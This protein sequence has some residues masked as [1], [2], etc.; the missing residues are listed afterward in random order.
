VKV[1]TTPEHEAAVTQLLEQ[2]PGVLR[3]IA[4]RPG[5]GARTL[6]SPQDSSTAAP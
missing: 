1:L 3:T 6:P 2:I 4:T 5:D